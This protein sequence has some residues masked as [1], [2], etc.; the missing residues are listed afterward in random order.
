M[1]RGVKCF[2]LSHVVSGRAGLK[3][4]QFGFQALALQRTPHLQHE[5][6]TERLGSS[7]GPAIQW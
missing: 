4:G 5:A 3:P 1:L 7:P 2:A 6:G